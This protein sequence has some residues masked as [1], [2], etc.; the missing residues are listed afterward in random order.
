MV[1][2]VRAVEVVV[3]VNVDTVWVVRAVG[4]KKAIFN[5]AGV[6]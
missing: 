5:E 1:W 2:V 4:D 3:V 6:L